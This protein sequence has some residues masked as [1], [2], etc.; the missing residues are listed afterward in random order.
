[1]TSPRSTW[2]CTSHTVLGSPHYLLCPVTSSQLPR[3]FSQCFCCDGD[4]DALRGEKKLKN[5][6]MQG[7]PRSWALCL[8]CPPAL[9]ASSPHPSLQEHSWRQELRPQIPCN[10][11]CHGP[12]HVLLLQGA[13][14]SGKVWGRGLTSGHRSPLG[15]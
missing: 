10:P 9:A 2:C 4:S 13:R 3:V 5:Q 1:M 12:L 6:G 7:E 14:F 15:H 11:V 8:R